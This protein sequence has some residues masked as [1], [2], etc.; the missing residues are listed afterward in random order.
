MKNIHTTDTF[1]RL[2]VPTTESTAQVD[3]INIKTASRVSFGKRLTV[4]ESLGA[5]VGTITTDTTDSNFT[6]D[7]YTEVYLST[8]YPNALTELFLRSNVYVSS[9]GK[10]EL[11]ATVY[12]EKDYYMEL[13]GTVNSKT[14][15]VVIRNGGTYK[16]GSPANT[17]ISYVD[18]TTTSKITLTDLV[19]DNGG[20]IEHTSTCI[21]PTQQIQLEL[22]NYN[23]SGSY[24]FPSTYISLKSGYKTNQIS[25]TSTATCSG[26]NMY[27]YK[28]SSCE[29]NPGTH[30]FTS[31]TIEA[32]GTL[33]I[34]GDTHRNLTKINSGSINVM[35]GGKITGE[36]KGY[37]SGGPGAAA[38]SSSGASHGGSGK[39]NPNK[40]Y[41]SI[42]Y[43]RHYGS[44]GQGSVAGGG[45]IEFS[46]TN[47]FTLNGEVNM[48][49]ASGTSGGSGGS[50]LI[51]CKTLTGTGKILAQ[52]GSGGGGGGRISIISSSSFD[53]GDGLTSVESADGNGSPGKLIYYCK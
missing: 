34:K 45:Q 7:S 24:S 53:F 2:P 31:I 20:N 16:I 40:L 50:I 47:T 3:E 15:I 4:G 13:C 23:I 11:P 33:T 26:L 36:G 46:V 39:D 48:N 5:T 32:G 41:G 14:K 9:Y 10:I 25:Q 37:T 27:I 28:G 17:G 18:T 30:T 19:I 29:L 22:T 44:N 52:G 51:Q 12:V 43:P 35:F 6:V 21:R 1:T 8:R 38:S 42:V 49:G